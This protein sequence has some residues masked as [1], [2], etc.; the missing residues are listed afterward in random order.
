[1][2]Q[3]STQSLWLSGG[4][5]MYDVDP[6]RPNLPLDSLRLGV[7]SVPSDAKMEMPCIY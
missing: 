4:F 1:M 2:A 7:V 5:F 3:K 6:L